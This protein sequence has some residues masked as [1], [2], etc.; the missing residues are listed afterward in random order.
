MLAFACP[1]ADFAMPVKAHRPFQGVVGLALVEAGLGPAPEIRVEIQSIMNRV[2][3]I[4][5][6]SRSAEASSFCRG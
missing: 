2:R 5:P 1:V 3:S 4:R 6:I